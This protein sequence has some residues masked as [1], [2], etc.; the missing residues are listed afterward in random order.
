MKVGV[1]GIG[2]MGE[3]HVLTYST[4]AQYCNLVGVYDNDLKKSTQISKKYNI[5]MFE[6]VTDLLKE[7]DAVSI[8]VPTEFHYEIGLLCI[9]HKVHI[10]M[11]KPIAF[12][13]DQAKI[14]KEK[15]DKA[16]IK[17]Q[18]GHIELFNPLIQVLKN[19][20][21]QAEILA[22][23]MHR[24][25][26]YNEKLKNIDVVQDLMIHD[27][28]IL[29]ELLDD[30]ITTFF[31]MGNIIESTPKHAMVLLKSSKE[32][33]AHITAS[34]KAPYKKRM[35]QIF[36]ENS[37]IEAD[38]LKNEIK[39]IKSNNEISNT[40]IIHTETQHVP[41]TSQPLKNQLLSFINCIKNDND[42][43]VTAIHG[44]KALEISNA[45]SRSLL[46]HK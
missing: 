4:L 41:S 23:Y 28:Y 17:F 5:L 11:E 10:L 18:V 6:H 8:A 21:T 26:P 32:V 1:I 13:I 29:E 37:Y 38:L 33:V 25:S 35:I 24:M 19:K 45:I 31:S 20:M 12:S 14:L 40:S 34:F 39:V 36:Q 43:R 7:V 30:E 3:K 22:I 27:L 44:I 15:A 2:N 16:G 46:K 42:P 9:Q